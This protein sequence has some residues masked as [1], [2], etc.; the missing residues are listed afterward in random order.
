MKDVSLICGGGGL[1]GAFIAGVLTEMLELW[2]EEFGQV[3]SIFASSASVGGLFYYLSHRE[4]HP[5]VRIW[6][7]DIPAAPFLNFKGIGSLF[8]A[9]PVYD[10]DVLVDGVFKKQNPYDVEAIKASPVKFFFPMV[11]CDSGEVEVFANLDG[12]DGQVL[13]GHLYRDWRKHDIYTMVKAAKA[14]PIFYD[15]ALKVGGH[16]YV[17]GDAMLPALW[18]LPGTEQ[19]RNIVILTGSLTSPVMGVVMAALGWLW[20]AL[21]KCG[22]KGNLP[23]RQYVSFARKGGI[24]KR[25]ARKLAQGEKDGAVLLITPHRKLYPPVVGTQ[26]AMQHNFEVGREYVRLQ[27]ERIWEFWRG[28]A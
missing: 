13:G 21:A 10:I 17:D 4:N 15:R 1:Q 27:R 8:G 2:P 11:N 5:G 22:F 9:K 14:L 20:Y 26:A 7:Q 24:L 12:C 28:A 3:R 25:L 19:N 16:A 18:P 23:P 6:T